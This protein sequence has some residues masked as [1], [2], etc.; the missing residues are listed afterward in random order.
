MLRT[1][2]TGTPLMVL[3]LPVAVYGLYYLCPDKHCSV[4]E[5]PPSLPTKLDDVWSNQ[6]ALVALAWFALQAFLYMVLPATI[7][8]GLPLRDGS[9]LPYRINALRCFI[10]SAVLLAAGQLT[11]QFSLSYIADNYIQL[12]TA[13][14][15][16]SYALSAWLYVKSCKP[17]AMLAEGG[18]SG[19]ERKKKQNKRK[20]QNITKRKFQRV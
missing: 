20:K 18:N 15:V 5:F 1:T 6:A 2:L 9:T 4:M 13:A 17:D 12:A 19:L 10:V 7:V 8:Q 3:G 11:G 16:F 14:M